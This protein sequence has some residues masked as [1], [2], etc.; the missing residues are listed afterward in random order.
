[1]SRLSCAPWKKKE[2]KRDNK[3]EGEYEETE[4]DVIVE[5]EEIYGGKLRRGRIKVRGVLKPKGEE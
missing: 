2:R 4:N 1:M 5:E 3:E